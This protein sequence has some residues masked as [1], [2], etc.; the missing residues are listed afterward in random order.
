MHVAILKDVPPLNSVA[1]KLKKW[2]HFCM[3]IAM[4]YNGELR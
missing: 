1:T 4:D 2:L 3:K